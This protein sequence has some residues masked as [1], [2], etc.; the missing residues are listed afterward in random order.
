MANS[1]NTQ[2]LA[3][4]VYAQL[5]FQQAQRSAD[6]ARQNAQT[7]KA[8]AD[9]AQTDAD[10]AQENARTLRVEANDAQSESNRLSLGLQA[11]KSMGDTLTRQHATHTQVAG[12][13][14]LPPAQPAINTQG[15]VTGQI[16]DVSA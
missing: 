9:A 4:S 15:Q 7:L 8:Q 14:P 11:Q 13:K 3:Q 5:Q 16:V 6:Q 1:I 10:Q 12:P 2:S